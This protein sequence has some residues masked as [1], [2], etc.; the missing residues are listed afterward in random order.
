LAG[1]IPRPR[2]LLHTACGNGSPCFILPGFNIACRGVQAPNDT[3]GLGLP[4]AAPRLFSPEVSYTLL[5]EA[6]RDASPETDTVAGI[7]P[8]WRKRN[9]TSRSSPS[10]SSHRICAFPFGSTIHETVRG[11]RSECNLTSFGNTCAAP[12]GAPGASRS[13]DTAVAYM[14]LRAVRAVGPEVPRQ[15]TAALAPGLSRGFRFAPRPP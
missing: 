7:E 4:Q 12:T 8:H 5:R 15:M 9:I 13:V 6:P 1:S 3:R 10:V 11:S 2:S 14:Y